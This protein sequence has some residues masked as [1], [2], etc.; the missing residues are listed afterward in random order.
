MPYGNYSGT[1]AVDTLRPTQVALIFQVSYILKRLYSIYA[2]A[3]INVARLVV[4]H[5]R[6]DIISEN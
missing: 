2:G 1:Y 3:N 5:H 6:C 4:D